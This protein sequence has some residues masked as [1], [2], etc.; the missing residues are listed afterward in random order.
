MLVILLSFLATESYAQLLDQSSDSP[1]STTGWAIG[2][3][4]AQTVTV[5]VDGFLSSIEL[6]IYQSDEIA[7]GDVAIDIFRTFGTGAP[8]RNMLLGTVVIENSAIP[9][10][11]Q[12]NEAYQFASADFSSQELFFNAGDRFAIVPRRTDLSNWGTSPW[13]I[14]GGGS[15]GSY[16]NGNFYL[17]SLSAGWGQREGAHSFRTFMS[18]ESA[19]APLLLGD[20][21]QDGTVNFL[22]IFPFIEI[23]TS[24]SYLE[25]A[26]FN[27]TGEVTFLD[28]APFIASL[29][30]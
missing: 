15:S 18:A 3:R 1:A 24:G 23:L 7:S 9:T 30:A 25:E 4:N 19:V 10:R 13:F 28:I 22:D 29:S 5:G 26:D 8:D 2:D 12:M 21:N 14:W 17:F 6:P 27:Q 11:S 20:C 16:D